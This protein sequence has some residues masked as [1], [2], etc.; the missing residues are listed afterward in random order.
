LEPAGSG[1]IG[2]TSTHLHGFGGTLYLGFGGFSRMDRPCQ[3]WKLPLVRVSS[4]DP[5]R[6]DGENCFGTGHGFMGAITDF[7]RRVYF[8]TAGGESAIFRT[9]GSG[10][11][12]VTPFP[13]RNITSFA[14]VRKEFSGT[15]LYMGMGHFPHVGNAGVFFTET[16][17]D[18]EE[19]YFS[20]FE[21]LV[22]S[23]LASHCAYLYAGTLNNGGFEVLRRTALLVDLTPCIGIDVHEAVRELGRLSVC[24]LTEKCPID[25]D[26]F[27]AHLASIRDALESPR[28]PL[29]DLRL[30]D[31]GRAMMKEAFAEFQVAEELL[32]S[33]KEPSL[34]LA[35]QGM[36]HLRTSARFATDTWVHLKTPLAED[37]GANE[38]IFP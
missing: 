36:E 34:P 15:R 17:G 18:W 19:S 12:D 20:P 38:P 30:V 32:L 4:D 8:G 14:L 24:V 26:P 9:L 3:V 25:L 29:D 11:E 7:N 31:D 5:I 23:D 13:I 1:L 33:Q 28:H 35:L 22:T 2:V 10:I 6:V 37:G 27:A 16:G 21:N